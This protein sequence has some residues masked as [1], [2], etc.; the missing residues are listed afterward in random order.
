MSGERCDGAGSL[1]LPPS[2]GGA[3]S[4]SPAKAGTTPSRMSEC[5]SERRGARLK[6]TSF[7]INLFFR[8]TLSIASKEAVRLI[9]RGSEI[10]SHWDSTQRSSAALTA[11]V[12]VHF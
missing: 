3:Q 2:L 6:L 5:Q 9:S 11:A 7:H 1:D 12:R 10:R 8:M 4:Q